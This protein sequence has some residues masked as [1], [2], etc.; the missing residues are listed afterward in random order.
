[1]PREVEAFA[2]VSIKVVPGA[3]RDEIAGML[4]DRVKVRVSAPAEGGKANAAV[5]GLI[6]RAVGVRTR[7]VRIVSG[8]TSE[9]KVVE[10]AGV[11]GEDVCR[12]LGLGD[13]RPRG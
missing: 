9:E 5:C 10:I 8:E 3:R 12:R 2:R 4:G 13:G 11:S 6:A 7:D 1:M